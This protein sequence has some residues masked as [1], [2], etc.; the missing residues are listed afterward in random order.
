MQIIDILSKDKKEKSHPLLY[1]ILHYPEITLIDL[2]PLFTSSEGS[3]VTD[4]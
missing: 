2:N 3:S 1:H 4:V